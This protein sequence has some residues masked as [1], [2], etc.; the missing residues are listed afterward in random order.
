[1]LHN[2]GERDDPEEAL[3]VPTVSV[4]YTPE[5]AEWQPML[6]IPAICVLLHLHPGGSNPLYWIVYKSVWQDGCSV[7]YKLTLIQKYKQTACFSLS[8]KVSRELPQIKSSNA[9]TLCPQAARVLLVLALGS[10]SLKHSS[11]IVM[12]CLPLEKHVASGNLE[13]LWVNL[14]K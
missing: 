10:V 1:M 7:F 11:L 13:K 4:A 5:L 2:T 3:G 8:S 14:N 9:S 6:I 12:G